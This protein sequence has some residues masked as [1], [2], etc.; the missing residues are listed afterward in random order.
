MAIGNL[1]ESDIATL[2]K[3]QVLRGVQHFG[4]TIGFVGVTT[5]TLTATTAILADEATI[6][7]VAGSGGSVT[8]TGE[9]TIANGT[10][11]QPILLVGTNDTNTVVLQDI[12]NLAG[13]NLDLGGSDIILANTDYL[14]LIFNELNTNWERVIHT[15]N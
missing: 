8:L 14:L 5:Q 13:S 2:T 1:Q 4:N 6:I 15:N 11:W 12:S 3:N 10:P 9:P 7:P